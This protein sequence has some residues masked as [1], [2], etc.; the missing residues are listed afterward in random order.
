MRICVVGMA[1]GEG[2]DQQEDRISHDSI[3][4]VVPMEGTA[5]CH[6]DPEW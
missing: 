1:D 4:S 6:C 2:R 5:S 3:I